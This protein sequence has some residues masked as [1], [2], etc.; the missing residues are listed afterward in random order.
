MVSAAEGSGR[1]ADMV[2]WELAVMTARR[3]APAGP[4]VDAD[5]ARAVVADLKAFAAAA[6]D[7]FRSYTGLDGS[8]AP[9]PLVV[10]D[11]PGWSQANA[12]GMRQLIDPLVA[13][14]RAARPG[15]SS[16]LVEGVGPK[17]TGVE[18]G[19]L[20]AFLSSKVLGQFDPFYG[21]GD[22]AVGRLLLVAPNVVQVERELKVD[23]RDF[24]LWVCLH[25]ETHRVQF[26]A[27]PWLRDHMRTQIARFVEATD[28]DPS[29]LLSRLRAVVEAVVDSARGGDSDGPSLIDLVQ[30][31]EQ[32]VVLD[33]VTATMSLLEGHADVVMDGVG[34]QVVPSVEEIRTK[35][36]RRRRS[37]S[38]LDRTVRRLLGLEAKM[39]QYRD[40]ARFV[41][42][43]VD[44]VGMVGFNRVWESAETLPTL[45]EISDPEA[46]VRR[47]H[48]PPAVTA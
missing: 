13:K 35:F 25:E 45:E 42:G 43:A 44:R 41:R 27:V 22:G 33:R 48:G 31:P 32:K 26:T 40:G 2:D 24:R 38:G 16:P 15:P 4:V 21:D 30:S 17:L 46:W 23:P 36:Q 20:L 9:A 8:S 34:P 28:V 19:A 6:E 39:R 37:S 1:P 10:V 3:L 18:T 11:R 47:V 7:P 29:V 14:L 12:D 5:E